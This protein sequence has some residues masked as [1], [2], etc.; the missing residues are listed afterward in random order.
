MTDTQKLPG[1]VA[2]QTPK[3]FMSQPEFFRPK[4]NY[5]QIT[6]G[7]MLTE[8]A[9]RYPE[10]T[11]LI[12]KDIDLS[13]RELDSLTNSF[14]N[15]LYNLG[16]RKGDR[17]CLYMTNRPEYVIS[18]YAIAR[19]GAVVSPMNPSYKEREVEYQLGNS[20]ALAIVCQSELLPIVETARSNSPSLKYVIAVGPNRAVPNGVLH[21]ADLIS[22]A[23]ATPPPPVEIDGEDLLAL[24]YSSGT[25]GLPK[26]VMLCH[27]NL[28][29]N[30][31]QMSAIV[32]YTPQ[33]KALLFLPFY[34]IYGIM[35]MGA[36]I[37]SGTTSVLMERFEP[38]EAFRLVQESGI[39][40][41]FVAPPVLVM[42]ANM[43]NLN[44][45]DFKTV[46]FVMSG[47]APVALEVVK[48]VSIAID[49][50]VTQ[51]YGLSEASPITHL[52]PVIK[53][54]MP[55]EPKTIGLPVH[56]TE[57]KIVDIE[58]GEQELGPNE[59][60]E[61]IIRGPQVM[62][63]Y[64]KAPEATAATLRNGWLYTGDIGAIDER[65][66]VTISDR[67]KEMIKFKGF[68]IAPAEIEALLFEHPA[69]ADV[70]VVP[71]PDDEAGELP[72]AYIVRKSS[73]DATEQEILD[74]ANGKLAGYKKV[75]EVEF[76]DAIPK[77][78]SGKILRRI[79]K[80]RERQ[81]IAHQEE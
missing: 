52:N 54:G 60:G 3:P 62:Q 75:H 49:S 53:C 31:I 37:Y 34:H 11:A 16:I 66:Y 42:M 51:G 77:N 76:I 13:F 23:P 26:G 7:Q 80:E 69:V 9:T 15:A 25:T 2:A 50:Y 6:F 74:F 56:D 33:D 79:L 63:G 39:T 48:K 22:K 47:A 78:P 18:F 58:T 68:G 55:N 5:P 24:P 4:L 81:K 19:L 70:A 14:A 59:V 67:K 20:E 44:A 28:V 46:R 71:K 29:C 1:E 27:R 38:T 41:M 36:S 32:R 8:S 35:L 45:E 73:S 72:K 61:L 43:S 10:N 17:I 30:Y 65:G 57:Q 21:F 64:W 40:L 12:F